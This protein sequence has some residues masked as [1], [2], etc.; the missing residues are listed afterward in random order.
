MRHD[1]QPEPALPTMSCS[2]L[3][4]VF[5]VPVAQAFL[6]EED[7]SIGVPNSPEERWIPYPRW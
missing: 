4:L 6:I 2:L 5:D 3:K 1:S 7:A